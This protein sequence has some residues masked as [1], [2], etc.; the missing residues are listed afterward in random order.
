METIYREVGSETFEGEKR[1]V[2]EYLSE[3]PMPLNVVIMIG[4]EGDFSQRE[5]SIAREK[6]FLPV[7]LGPSRLRV[8][9]AAVAAVGEIYFSTF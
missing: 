5:I 6:G 7:T 9:T 2:R 3:S 1:T 8:E 4:P